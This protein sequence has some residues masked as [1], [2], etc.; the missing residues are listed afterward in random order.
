MHW[1]DAKTAFEALGSRTRKL[2][3]SKTVDATRTGMAMERYDYIVAKYGTS[4]FE[5]FIGRK[6][7]PIAYSRDSSSLR[8]FAWPSALLVIVLVGVGGSMAFALTH[9]Y[10]SKEQED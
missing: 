1:D 7:T 5:D 2:L 6:P 10:K 4:V 3:E 9:H 8:E